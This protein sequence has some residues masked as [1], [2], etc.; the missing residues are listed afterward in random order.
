NSAV[1]LFV[2]SIIVFMF[3]LNA[4]QIAALRFQKRDE[5]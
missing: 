3:G 1:G 4:E 5:G 2:G